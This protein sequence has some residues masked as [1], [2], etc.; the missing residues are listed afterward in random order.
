MFESKK[1]WTICFTL[2]I[3]ILK[4]IGK[5]FPINTNFYRLISDIEI[6]NWLPILPTNIV[7]K[8]INININQI[9]KIDKINKIDKIDGEWIYS[10]KIKN[11]KKH[12]KYFLYIHGGAFCMCK[13]G[14]YRGLLY[15]I[16]KKTNSVIFS[17]NY[18]RSPEYKY[19]IP[20]NDCVRAYLYL[21]NLKIK[22]EN[23]ILMGDSAGG[24]LVIYLL[25]KLINLN[26]SL[27][28][29]CI[30]IS[31]WIDL[32]DF[33]KNPSWN[34]NKNYDFIIPELAKYFSEQYIDLSKN[35]LIDVSPLFLPDTV[36]SKFPPILIEYGD[37]EVLYDQ[38]KQF[39]N[40]LKKLGINIKCICRKDMIHSFPIFYFTGISQ[41]EDFFKSVKKFIK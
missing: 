5:I 4:F 37:S 31:P 7:S 23:I 2:V 17:I 28:S 32:T 13:I 19:P 27:P 24:N 20:L 14:I 1:S 21:L 38:I 22:P 36:L 8:I 10:K 11:Y 12:N 16:A 9:D 25:A 3:K 39:C 41:A 29:K 40:K 18:R 26:I 34:K 30:L 35:N 15:T 33:D 6:P